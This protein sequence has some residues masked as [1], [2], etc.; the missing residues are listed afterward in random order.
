VLD[1]HEEVIEGI[2]D[3]RT[4]TRQVSRTFSVVWQLG[5]RSNMSKDRVL[6]LWKP[7]SQAPD[8]L[9]ANLFER[10]EA[11]L[12]SNAHDPLFN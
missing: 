11:I 6:D 3:R 7:R 10:R 9:N 8:Q 5:H 4:H 12:S 2:Y 1:A